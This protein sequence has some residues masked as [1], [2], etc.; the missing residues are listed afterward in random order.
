MSLATSVTHVVRLSDVRLRR[1]GRAVLAGVTADVARGEVVA[2]MGP[3]GS[4]KTTILRAI[5]G[6]DPFEAGTIEVDGVIVWRA[7]RPRARRSECSAA[8]SEWSSSF[9]CLFEHLPALDNVWLAPVHAHEA[10]RADAERQAL[11]LLR[12]LGVDH[13]A[14]RPCRASCLVEKPSAWPSRARS[15]SIRRCC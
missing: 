5:A 2:L 8:R 13:R 3:S 12:T 14:L 11:A 10:P 9:H 4:G 15:P 1:G 6:L 7:A